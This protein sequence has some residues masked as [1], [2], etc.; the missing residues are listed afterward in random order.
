MF[1]RRHLVALALLAVFAL[2][3][4]GAGGATPEPS[5]DT[6]TSRPAA[7]LPS[8]M[9]ALGDSITAGFG[10]CLAFVACSRNSWSTGT[11]SAVDSHYRRI[12]EDNPKIKG[13]AHNFAEPG[14]E[15]DALAGQADRAVEVKAQ[16]VT[17]LIG[18]NDACAASVRNMTSAAQ[19]RKEV[20]RGLARLKKGLPKARVLVVSV[21][22][23]Y[24][25]WELGRDDEQAVRV[26]SQSDICPSMLANPASTAR[27][28]QERREQVRD[29]IDAYNE[30]L[31]KACR[32]YGKRC[33]WDGG[34]AHEV[35]FSL[36]LVNRIDYFHPN[37]EGQNEL[38][39]VVFPGRFNW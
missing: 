18:A 11:S 3:C 27:A 15:A 24:R 2:A 14:A 13:E 34:R 26:W 6:P 4:E 17:V 33:R 20:D 1:R 30:Q 5:G 25:L 9:A 29:R 10:S 39:D 7:A 23:L 19:F 12:L 37:V 35:R 21:P 32:A 36:D 16:Y 38:A 22:D 28:D 31:R 8:S